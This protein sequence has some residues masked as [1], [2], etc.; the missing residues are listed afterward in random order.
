MV[1]MVS[2]GTEATMTAIRLARGVTGRK[3]IKFTG[4][5]HGHADS[6][7]VMGSVATLGYPE[8]RCS[9][10]G[11]ADAPCPTTIR[12]VRDAAQRFGGDLA[13]SS[14][15]RSPAN[16]VVPPRPGFLK[17]HGRLPARTASSGSSTR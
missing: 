16:G 9:P 1:R 2:S 3:I 11:R 8:A 4:C 13:V 17:R 10:A 7:R 6:P 12:R 5:H 15:N 14:S